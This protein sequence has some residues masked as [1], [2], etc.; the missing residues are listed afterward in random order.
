M[1]S[2]KYNNATLVFFMS[3]ISITEYTLNV[4]VD[5]DVMSFM[6]I[7]VHF[8]GG[9]RSTEVLRLAAGQQVE[10][11]ILHFGHGLCACASI[12]LQFRIVT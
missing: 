1:L 11:S 6:E 5:V 2:H 3:A 12:A 9:N 10:R 4:R 7:F 8:I